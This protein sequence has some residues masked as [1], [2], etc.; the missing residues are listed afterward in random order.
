MSLV[1]KLVS[2]AMCPTHVGQLPGKYL[3][4]LHDV[5]V[6]VKIECC[7]VLYSLIF[8]SYPCPCHP[9]IWDKD[10]VAGSARLPPSIFAFLTFKGNFL[11][12]DLDLSQFNL[13]SKVNSWI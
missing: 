11:L 13:V 6:I 9:T 2:T 1:L 12:L 10:F 8:V 7:M 4:L 5:N 3:Q